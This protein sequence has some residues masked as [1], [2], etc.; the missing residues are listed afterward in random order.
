M[1]TPRTSRSRSLPRQVIVSSSTAALLV[2]AAALP[3]SAD[4]TA[5]P[6]AGDVVTCTIAGAAVPL[7]GTSGHMLTEET[8][9]V[10]AQGHAR[11]LFTIRAHD[12]RLAGPDGTRY[13]LIGGG[14]DRVLYPTEIN[15]GEVL[16]ERILFHFDVIGPAGRV[17]VVRF[18]LHAEA[19][20]PP[21]VTDTSTC[22]LPQQ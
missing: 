8:T 15:T 2:G 11:S 16:R 12:A 1:N 13:R 19:G 22:Q 21:A 10:D 9:H 18:S 7:V 17:G 14:F 5:Q 3:A 20:E 6:I 4:P